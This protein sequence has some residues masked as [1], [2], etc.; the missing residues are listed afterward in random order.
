M[1]T[2]FFF[3]VCTSQCLYQMFAKI[4]TDF[5]KK[6]YFIQIF[7][8]IKKFDNI[9]IDKLKNLQ[10]PKNCLMYFK[11]KCC[12]NYFLNQRLYQIWLKLF[13]NFYSPVDI[14]IFI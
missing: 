10:K 12:L 1:L 7:E 9:V 11:Y 8:K 6:T 13:K 14:N 4:T 2:I 3:N 5:L